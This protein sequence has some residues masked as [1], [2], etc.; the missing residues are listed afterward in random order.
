MTSTEAA[1][2]DLMLG[3][4]AVEGDSVAAAP[5]PALAQPDACHTGVL[6]TAAYANDIPSQTA[7]LVALYN[8]VW[9][10][11]ILLSLVQGCLA[12]P[13]NLRRSSK[14]SVMEYMTWE[15]HGSTT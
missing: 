13:T 2:E 12:C 10:A 6:A 7:A 11:A 5:G 4:A 14:L 15:T 3:T 8:T 9:L 1:A